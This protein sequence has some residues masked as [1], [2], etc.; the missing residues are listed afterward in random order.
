MN[1]QCTKCEEV[2]SF[3][4]FYKRK[5]KKD[6]YRN[7]CIECHK[8]Y[9]KD[10]KEKRKVWVEK[11]RLKNVDK[12]KAYKHKY[13][14]ENK[15]RLREVGKKWKLENRKITNEET[16][17]KPSQYFAK[18]NTHMIKNKLQIEENINQLQNE[19]VA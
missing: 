5:I 7:R 10:N 17:I 15:D 6:G 3:D 1:K 14:L 11:Y 4:M 2:K 9:N 13:Y 19:E 16:K 18:E 12:M 8:K